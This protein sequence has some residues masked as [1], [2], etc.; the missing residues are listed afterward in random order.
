[1]TEDISKD[2]LIQWQNSSIDDF[3]KNLKRINDNFEDYHVFGHI[4]VDNRDWIQAIF[5]ERFQESS[6]IRQQILRF[7]RILARDRQNL[8]RLLSC[9]LVQNVLGVGLLA[10]QSFEFDWESFI[11]AEMCLVNI[12]F[13]SNRARD[14]FNGIAS[15]LLLNR[16]RLLIETPRSSS[17]QQNTNETSITFQDTAVSTKS[18]IFEFPVKILSNEQI[19]L[20]TF[21]DLRI[22]FVASAQSKDLQLQWLKN[23]CEV[24]L[25][26]LEKSLHSPERLKQNSHRSSFVEHTNWA[27]KVLFNIF[28]YSWDDSAESNAKRCMSL[29]AKIVILENVD[30]SLEQSAVDVIAVLPLSY[31]W[32]TPKLQH[33]EIENYANVVHG[34]HDMTFADAVLHA[35][36]R[37][38]EEE[39]NE[40]NEL[41][42]TFL[43]VLI[44]L[45]SQVKEARRYLRLLVIPPLHATDVERRPDDGAELR[46]RMIRLMMSISNTQD[47]AAE[48]IFILCKKSVNRFV[49]YCGFGHAAGLLA[50]RG[51]LNALNIPKHQSDSEASETEDYKAVE[52]QVNPVTGCIEPV[53]ESPFT[54]MT[55]EQKEYEM[56]RLMNDI[57]KLMNQGLITPG[58]IGKDGQLA[59]VKHVLELVK[60]CDAEPDKSDSE[61]DVGS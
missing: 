45:S 11:Q 36:E 23:G 39:N 30:P 27:L 22:A 7:L 6:A 42:G 58:Q 25:K 56:H 3:V 61:G 35:L 51:I 53:G 16:I 26:V 55:E 28:C 41:L 29:C 18:K 37:R 5:C 31:E 49:K 47:L 2:D 40:R 50:N 34:G 17:P 1:M 24:F 46:N 21:Y 8:D 19:D 48:F 33:T 57:N 60:D 9:I 32:L 10:E 13:N 54:G 12:L 43:T 15:N 14:E 4:D 52:T 20:V 38:L 59:P 44:R